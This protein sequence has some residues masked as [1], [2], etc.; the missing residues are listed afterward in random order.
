MDGRALDYD[1]MV[2]DVLRETAT[3]LR[4]RYLHWSY[5]AA[6]PDERERWRLEALNVR[7]EVDAVDVYDE[8]AVRAKTTELADR[9]RALP[10][11]EPPAQPER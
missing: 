6:D 9:L 1:P 10:P 11:A 5:T 4:G 8:A 2:Y 7:R 3:Q